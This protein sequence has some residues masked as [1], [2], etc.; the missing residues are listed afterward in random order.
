MAIGWVKA[1]VG[2]AGNKAADVAVQRGARMEERTGVIL[3]VSG[4]TVVQVLAARRKTRY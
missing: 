2:I 4:R 1:H 3:G